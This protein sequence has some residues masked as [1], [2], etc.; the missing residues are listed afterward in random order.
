M[1]PC[2]PYKYTLY[3]T[4]VSHPGVPYEGIVYIILNPDSDK[5]ASLW[6]HTLWHHT[7]TEAKPL[8]RSFL[9]IT[10]P[11]PQQPQCGRCHSPGSFDGQKLWLEGLLPSS[12]F[13]P[14]TPTLAKTLSGSQWAFVLVIVSTAYHE[15]KQLFILQLVVHHLGDA[16][17][18]LRADTDA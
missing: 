12:G 13:L 3:R 7:E 6:H 9:G 18:E 14:E 5:T 1:L 11:S 17:K 8:L 10:K 2:V 15:Q 16:G 4:L